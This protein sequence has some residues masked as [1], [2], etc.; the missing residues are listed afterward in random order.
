MDALSLQTILDLA[1]PAE[2]LRVSLFVP[3]QRF[4][5]GSQEADSTRLKNLVRHAETMLAARGLRAAEIDRLLAPA[6]AL[7]DDRPLWLRSRDGLVVLLGEDGH[8]VFQVDLPVAEH[9]YI[10]HRFSIRPLLPMVGREDSYWVLAL[11]QKRVRLLKGDRVS[12]TEVPSEHIPGS[13][14][15]ALQWEDFEKASLQFHTGTSGT[16]GRRPPVFHGTGEPDP[17]NELVRFFRDID[18]GLHEHLGDDHA[19]LVLAGVDYL[20]PLYREISTCPSL[21]D[22]AVTGNPDALGELT[23]HE[24]S[25]AIVSEALDRERDRLLETVGDMWASPRVL[26]EPSGIVDAAAAGRIDSLLLSDDAGVWPREPRG[27]GAA[28]PTDD[29]LLES[30]AIGTLR[31]SGTVVVFPAGRMP[32]EEDAVALLRY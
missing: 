16:A 28:E 26:T 22:D 5:P 14:S 13:L 21:L 6:R 30:A 17:K 24:R 15:D 29:D 4:G 31:S 32:H 9:V 19:P 18:R 25:W 12:L 7:F 1:R 3:T 2:S 11:S 10:G 23:L 8:H 20:M 27:T